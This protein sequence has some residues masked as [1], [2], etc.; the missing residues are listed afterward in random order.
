M[1]AA[2][3]LLSTGGKELKSTVSEAIKD[4]KD[5]TSRFPR[6]T[7]DEYN[8]RLQK[9]DVTDGGPKV[10][11][12]DP[13]SGAEEVGEGKAVTRREFFWDEWLSYVA[14]AIVALSLIDLSVEFVAT[15]RQG[16]LC[17]VNV[18]FTFG[19][20]RYAYVNSYCARFL[21]LGQYY[22]LFTL[23]Q[24]IVLLSPHYIWLSVCNG[25]FELF[26]AL[27]GMLRRL[28]ERS[29]GEY[30]PRNYAIIKKLHEEFVSKKRFGN[31]ILIGYRVKLALQ[32]L[33]ALI[34]LMS[35]TLVFSD[36]ETD[37]TCPSVDLPPDETFGRV[38]CVY[39]RLYFLSFV[40]VANLVLLGLGLAAIFMGALMIFLRPHIEALGFEEQ[41]KFAYHAGI[42]HSHYQPKTAYYIPFSPFHI[43][44]DLDFMLVRL[45]VSD[46]GYGKIFKD[47]QISDYIARLLEA[48]FKNLH[49][50]SHIRLEK[51]RAE[52]AKQNFLTLGINEDLMSTQGETNL[53][54]TMN[55]FIAS[56]CKYVD[57]ITNPSRQ[58]SSSE[59]AMP[60]RR[61]VIDVCF[62]LHSYAFAISRYFEKV[63]VLHLDPNFYVPGSVVKYDSYFGNLYT[64]RAPS[65]VLALPINEISQLTN[66]IREFLEWKKGEWKFQT[67]LIIVSGVDDHIK[68]ATVSQL[69]EHFVGA[70]YI[71]SGAIVAILTPEQVESQ[72]VTSFEKLQ[73]T[74]NY[75]WSE[76]NILHL[77]QGFPLGR[78]QH[79]H[80]VQCGNTR[81]VFN[82]T[83]YKRRAHETSF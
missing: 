48:D 25:Y 73:L 26:F 80:P 19:R 20:D 71:S 59:E 46:A 58:L 81:C 44:T 74:S 1:A 8:A 28:K 55:A 50:Y 13:L 32:G 43:K 76:E 15:G 64:L 42:N 54:V 2:G 31:R 39:G 18:T 68:G 22:T 40:R 27:V 57:K 83:T 35:C 51:E 79:P 41:A 61:A 60:M 30:H 47:V 56:L 12:G 4:L 62:H 9:K 67:P 82:L 45:F 16:L 49:S 63:L 3:P 21:P 66:Q 52:D 14:S 7:K 70:S 6:V 17:D 77:L 53:G 65:N 23:I 24:G 10:T 78:G 33:C 69:L 34:F 5:P 36:F 37:L 11:Q 75:Q 72:R 38:Q 29:T